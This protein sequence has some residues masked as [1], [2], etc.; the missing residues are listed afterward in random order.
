VAIPKAGSEAAGDH[1]RSQEARARC[2]DVGS[3]AVRV[4]YGHPADPCHRRGDQGQARRH[5]ST[6]LSL[7][8]AARL[9][10]KEG[11]SPQQ[12]AAWDVMGRVPQELVEKV[13]LRADFE[14]KDMFR[15]SR[16]SDCSREVQIPHPPHIVWMRNDNALIE[17]FQEWAEIGLSPEW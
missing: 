15:R 2:G 13:V 16:A 10:L 8:A 7:K 6:L 5:T 1:C 12:R 9:S 4:G 3:T 17:A 14:T 11:I